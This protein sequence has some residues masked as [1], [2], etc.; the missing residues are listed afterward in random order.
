MLVE[1]GKGGEREERG[2][3]REGGDME[4]GGGGRVP[5]RSQRFSHGVARRIVGK[6]TRVYGVV[7]LQGQ[8]RHFR[9]KRRKQLL[10]P[11]ESGEDNDDEA[12]DKYDDETKGFA[13]VIA[14]TYDIIYENE[15]RVNVAENVPRGSVDDD[16]G[17]GGGVI[18]VVVEREGNY[19]AKRA[20]I[21]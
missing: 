7:A 2:G 9:R 16:G 1:G 4:E 17:G 12:E 11:G 18:V 21:L 3:G 10:L 13:S 15:V 19:S 14:G 6:E 5:S 20:I 8:G